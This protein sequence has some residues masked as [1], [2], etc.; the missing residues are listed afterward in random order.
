MM[1][2]SGRLFDLRP[3]SMISPIGHNAPSMAALMH[4]G[5]RTRKTT[6]KHPKATPSFAAA[7]LAQAF[8]V[9]NL[10]YSNHADF[11]PYLHHLSRA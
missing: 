11:N 6:T 1:S 7:T 9:I 8:K 10:N 2:K 5:I 4:Q 3:V